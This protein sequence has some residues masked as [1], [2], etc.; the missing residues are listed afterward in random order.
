MLDTPS[1]RPG[2]GSPPSRVSL[3][4]GVEAGLLAGATFL[5]LEYLSSVLFGAA[6][7]LGPAS[8]TLRRIFV[9]D[10]SAMVQ[11]YWPAVL[12]VHFTLS[13][14]TT[15]VLGYIIRR[16][17]LYWAVTFGMLYGLLLFVINFFGFA[18]VLPAITAA[19]DVFMAANYAIYGGIAAWAYKWRSRR[20]SRR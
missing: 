1:D 17:V 11:E 19:G 4:A 12:F 2:K 20:R 18:V 8:I 13:I 5:L 14:V 9:L 3:I 16:V 6:S 7:P 15:L 10:A